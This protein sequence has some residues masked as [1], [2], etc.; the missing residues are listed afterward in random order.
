MGALHATAEVPIVFGVHG[1]VL[2]VSKG[3]TLTGWKSQL[4]SKH[5]P[6]Q[7]PDICAIMYAIPAKMPWCPLQRNRECVVVILQLDPFAGD[8]KAATRP[9]LGNTNTHLTMVAIV[10]AG[11]KCPPETFAVKYTAACEAHN[12]LVS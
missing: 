8:H 3:R 10:T 12:L 4:T 6:K 11:F 9:L 5:I 2:A 1:K 7:A